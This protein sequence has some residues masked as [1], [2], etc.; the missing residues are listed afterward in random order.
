MSFQ[1]SHR[2]VQL[3]SLALTARIELEQTAD[4]NCGIS[5]I[6]EQSNEPGIEA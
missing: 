3:A 4:L 2:I 1:I 5:I 6:S